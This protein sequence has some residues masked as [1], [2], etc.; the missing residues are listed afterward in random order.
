MPISVWLA[1]ALA[2]VLALC[3]HLWPD[4]SVTAETVRRGALI[5]AIGLPVLWVTCDFLRKVR[6][7]WRRWSSRPY[8]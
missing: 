8:L 4:V 6:S 1:V 3:P 2:L 7:G 5:A